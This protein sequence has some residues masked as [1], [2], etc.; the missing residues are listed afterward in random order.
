M[1]EHAEKFFNKIGI[2]MRV[3]KSQLALIKLNFSKNREFVNRQLNIWLGHQIYSHSMV[4]GGLLV[5]S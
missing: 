5:T 3:F 1:R 2:G 4:P